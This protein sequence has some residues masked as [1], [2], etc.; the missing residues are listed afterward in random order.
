LKR[1]R[2]FKGFAALDERGLLIWGSLRT[3][4]DAARAFFE[5][6]NPAPEEHPRSPR[7]VPVTILVEDSA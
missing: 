7:I 5:R 1:V 2:T 3:R 4:A 6:H